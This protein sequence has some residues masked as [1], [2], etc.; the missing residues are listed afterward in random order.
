MNPRGLLL[1]LPALLGA[2]PLPVHPPAQVAPVVPS[3]EPAVAAKLLPSGE[4]SPQGPPA[5][6]ARASATRLPA[7]PSE[8]YAKLSEATRPQWRQ[9]YRPTVTRCLDGRQQAALALGAVVAD[10]FLAAQARDPQQ[11]RNLLQDEETIEKTL[12]LVEALASYRTEV[13]TA[14]EQSDWG[15]LSTGIEKLSGGERRYLRNQKDAPLA[16]L[17]YIGQWL[18]TFQTCHAVVIARGLEDQQLAIG[19][20]LLIAEMNRRLLTL[21]DPVTETNRCLRILHKR[22]S[23]LARLW[24]EDGGPVRDPA[25]RLRLSTELLGDA[26]GQL[27]QEE[28]TPPPGTFTAPKP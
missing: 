2:A 16:E 3:A 4:A 9:L 22:L 24:P 15:R 27:I 1:L 5:K 10:L 28:D 6:S 12:G 7:F 14:A 13:L 20:P 11:I 25:S 18:R 23:R 21:S 17:A 26:V 19:S 8:L